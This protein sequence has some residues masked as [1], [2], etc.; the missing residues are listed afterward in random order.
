MLSWWFYFKENYHLCDS[1]LTKARTLQALILSDTI[2][3]SHK[4]PPFNLLTMAFFH[5]MVDSC[6]LSPSDMSACLCSTGSCR[7]ARRERTL[8]TWWHS[9]KEIIFMYIGFLVLFCFFHRRK[10][11]VF[12]PVDSNTHFFVKFYYM[13]CIEWLRMAL[14][15]RFHSTFIRLCSVL[16]S[17]CPRILGVNLVSLL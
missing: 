14:S 11:T 16:G 3:S 7:N 8:W 15:L 17:I 1:T 4:L 2:T 9:C 5:W 12:H 10:D 13:L 6:N